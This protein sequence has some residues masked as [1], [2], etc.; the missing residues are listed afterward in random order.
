[1]PSLQV[2]RGIA[3]PCSTFPS[4]VLA[5]NHGATLSFKTSQHITMLP[6]RFAIR[7]LAAKGPATPFVQHRNFAMQGAV[8]P[9]PRREEPEP[10]TQ[11][12]HRLPNFRLTLTFLFYRLR[13][14]QVPPGWSNNPADLEKA[15]TIPVHRCGNAF[16]AAMPILV[17]VDHDELISWYLFA[18]GGKYYLYSHL[19]GS[20]H[21][22]TESRKLELILEK[23]SESSVGSVMTALVG[24]VHDDELGSESCMVAS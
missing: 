21:E 11:A 24:R 9:A 16:K 15:L 6:S 1:M 3:M 19:S 22:I 14:S 2:G 13:T 5:T 10:I 17:L 12:C 4:R 20:V 7:A 23:I 18:A 8:P